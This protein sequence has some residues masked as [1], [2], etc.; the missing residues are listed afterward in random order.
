MFKGRLP[1]FKTSFWLLLSYQ[2]GLS[3]K[4]LE[5]IIP[6]AMGQFWYNSGKGSYR[7]SIGKPLR[8]REGAEL[9]FALGMRIVV[10]F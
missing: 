2:N 7:K 10:T 4:I 5:L 9:Y 1:K 6:N 3:E 8:K